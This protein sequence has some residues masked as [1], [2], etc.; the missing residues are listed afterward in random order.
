MT[1]TH[2]IIAI[3]LFICIL[4]FIV[5]FGLWQQTSLKLKQTKD[6]LEKANLTIQSL[7]LDNNKL[8]QYT[9]EKDQEIKKIETQYKETLKNIPS[10]KCGDMKPSTKLLEFFRRNVQ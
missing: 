1:V 7:Q 5:F 6:S 8:L 3:T 4:G 2:K 9:K 10:D